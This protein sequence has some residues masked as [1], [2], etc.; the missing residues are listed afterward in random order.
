MHN[1]GKI[2]LGLIIVIVLLAF[3][4][5]YNLAGGSTDYV[6]ELEKPATATECVRSTEYMTAYH[7]DLLNDWRDEVVRQGVRFEINA[8]GVRYEKSLTNTCLGCHE[9]KDQFCDKCHDYMGVE[10]YCWECHI[11]PKEVGDGI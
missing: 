1:G 4:I 3:P 8:Q 5:W 11:V 2:I 10:P 6:P 7:M 9:N